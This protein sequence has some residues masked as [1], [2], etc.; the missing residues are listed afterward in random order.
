[1]NEKDAVNRRQL[2]LAAK[3]YSLATMAHVDLGGAES[4]DAERVRKLAAARAKTK[5]RRLGTDAAE[6]LCEDD[7]LEVAKRLRP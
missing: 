5:L 7:A 1:M 3:L 2:E 4:A 6:I